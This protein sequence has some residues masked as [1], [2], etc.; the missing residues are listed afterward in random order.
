MLGR[1]GVEKIIEYELNE[2]EMAALQASADAV[3]KSVEELKGLV[4]L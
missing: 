4:E 3:A 2:D 1:N